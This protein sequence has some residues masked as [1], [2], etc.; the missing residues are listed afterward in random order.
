MAHFSHCWVSVHPSPTCWL[1]NRWHRVGSRTSPPHARTDICPKGQQG[2]G[3]LGG[4]YDLETQSPPTGDPSPGVHF[5]GTQFTHL[6]REGELALGQL[7]GVLSRPCWQAAVG[8]GGYSRVRSYFHTPFA[9]PSARRSPPLPRPPLLAP[10]RRPFFTTSQRPLLAALAAI[11]PTLHP[12][13]SRLSGRRARRALPRLPAAAA[14]QPGIR[15]LRPAACHTR[16][17]PPSH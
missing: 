9:S 2:P 7:P 12:A 6:C 14:G 8:G 4:L 16:Q 17:T 13:T 15:S 3:Q 10:G 1:L 11:A 5:A